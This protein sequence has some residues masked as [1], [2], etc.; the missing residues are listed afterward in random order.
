[1]PEGH[2]LHEGTT[3][4]VARQL[5]SVIE[6]HLADQGIVL[7]KR[8][9]AVI[10]GML[11]NDIS[12][13][14]TADEVFSDADLSA[15]DEAVHHAIKRIPSILDE[16][17]LGLERTLDRRWKAE[18][19]RQLRA[20]RQF[21]K[22]LQL[23]WGEPL[24]LLERLIVIATELGQVVN[25]RLR[26]RQPCPNPFT[27]EVQTR[28]HARSCQTAREVLVLLSSGFAD[29]AL[30][31]WRA[32]HEMAVVSAF[33]GQDEELAE[34]YC[35]HEA[36]ESLRIVR[37]YRQY[38]T[39]LTL[40]P[41]TDKEHGELEQKVEQL[42]QR[43][44]KTYAGTYGWAA[45]KLGRGVT[46]DRIEG[47]INLDHLRPY[48]RLAS[49]SVHANPKGAFFR[50]GLDDQA[51]ILLAGPSSIGLAQA[52]QNTAI[53]LNQITAQLVQLYPALDHLAVAKA[54]LP[55]TNRVNQIFADVERASSTSTEN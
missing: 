30:A 35:L 51:A 19:K 7:K 43:F 26:A 52:G 47:A 18:K 38:T 22:E 5:L 55:L 17:A 6:E 2:P 44:G 33:I 20:L 28:L 36:V 40:D 42:K 45:G 9:R 50:L 1:M 15:I 34:R 53:S 49:H 29:G 41:I 37:Q 39:K 32:L 3:I 27:V 46:F 54:L 8:Q 10:R 14:K 11:Q 24:D 12:D 23:R 21:S 25:S 48:Y 13:S 31:R 4:S 16:L